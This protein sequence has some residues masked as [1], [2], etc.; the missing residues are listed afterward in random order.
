MKT[1]PV[2]LLHCSGSSGAQW[3]A[4]V[5]LLGGRHHVVTPDLIGYG[6]AAPWNGR[7]AF[8]LAQEAA[9]VRSILGQLNEPVHLV[10]HSYG[11]AV[12]LHI[13]RTR[14]EL[15]KSLTLIEPSAFHLLRGGDTIDVAA[16]GEI[17]AVAADARAALAVGDYAGGFGRFVDYWSGPGSWAAM[18][19][20]KRT[21]C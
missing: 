13:A 3:R 16:L 10:G 21:A 18:Q 15:V 9:P 17:T 6:A 8:C 12:A 4:L 1:E 5:A 20:D 19:Q 7:G 2:V 14:P 11:G